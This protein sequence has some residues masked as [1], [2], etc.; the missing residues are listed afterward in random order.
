MTIK[1][2]VVDDIQAN[3]K[4][5][6][7]RLQAESFE[8]L[9]AS[10]GLE[11]L[12]ICADGTPDVVLMDIRMP[13]MDGLSACCHLK[14]DPAT[15][16]IPVVIVTALDQISDKFAG[17]EA[18]ADDFLVKP[19]DDIALITR[20]RNLGRLKALSEEM[21]EYA[22]TNRNRFGVL[23]DTDLA[24]AMQC[25]R[26]HI[27]IIE[28]HPRGA[29]RLAHVLAQSHVCEIEADPRQVLLRLANEKFDLAIVNLDL[30]GADSLELCSQMHTSQEYGRLPVIILVEPGNETRLLRGLKIGAGDYLMH[31]IDRTDLLVR[32]RTQIKSKRYED[33]LRRRSAQGS[34]SQTCAIQS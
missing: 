25:E 2:L 30:A 4:L 5:L 15:L 7:A 28:R 29:Q 18:G 10:N 12:R 33:F 3:V 22:K 31:P 9:T 6:E 24:A 26:G 14:A 23:Q 21:S 19:V 8:V 13:Y 17:M 32:V 34:V 11:A 16:H 1:V 27:L 20:V